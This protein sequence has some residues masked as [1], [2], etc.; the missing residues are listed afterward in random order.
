LLA[1]GLFLPANMRPLPL[2]QSFLWWVLL[3]SHIVR[4]YFLSVLFGAVGAGGTEEAGTAFFLSVWFFLR[5]SL[6]FGLLSPM[7][8]SSRK[9]DQALA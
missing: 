4:S 5:F 9:P 8:V 6:F 7:E 1:R 2:G 3:L